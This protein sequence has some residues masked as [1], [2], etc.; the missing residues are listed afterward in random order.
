[1]AT[2]LHQ[3]RRAEQGTPLSGRHTA[4]QRTPQSALTPNDDAAEKAS[5]RRKKRSEALRKSLSDAFAGSSGEQQGKGPTL[6]QEAL[7]T[8]F[9]Q[10]IKLAAENKITDKN[11]WQLDL[12]Q[13]LPSIVQAGQAASLRGGGFNFQKMSGGLDAGVTIYSKRVDTTWKDVFQQLQGISSGSRGEDDGEDDAAGGDG[14]DDDD[15]EDAAAAAAKQAKSA[16]AAGKRGKA[17]AAREEATL[18]SADALRQKKVD[19]T[20]A[21]DPLFH[22]MSAL[23][24]EGGAKGLLLLNRSVYRGAAIMTDPHEVPE[25]QFPLAAAAEP[26]TLINMQPM[27]RQLAA[28]TATSSS[29]SNGGVLQLTPGLEQMYSLLEESLQRVQ[30][31]QQQQQQQGRSTVDV[32]AIMKQATRGLAPTPMPPRRRSSGQA[33]AGAGQADE[34]A[35]AADGSWGEEG[36]AGDEDY[37]GEDGHAGFEDDGEGEGEPWQQQQQQQQ[38][39]QSSGGHSMLGLGRSGAAE[40]DEVLDAEA[41]QQLL[42][43]SGFNAKAAPTTGGGWAGSSF[44]KYKSAAA[45][46]A[47]LGGSAAAAA[48]K[49]PAAGSKA[50]PGQQRIDF[51]SLPELPEGALERGS[52]KQTCL[53]GAAATAPTLLPQDL[54]YQASNL[55]QLFLKPAPVSC[56]SHLIRNAAAGGGADG[57]AA[58]GDWGGSDNDGEG[59]WGG[60]VYGDDDGEFGSGGDGYNAGDLSVG[61]PGFS[62]SGLGASEE[63][64]G[65]EWWGAEHTLLSA[66][67]RN[68]GLAVN[69]NRAAKQVD[70]RALKDLLWDSLV[71][72]NTRKTSA[73]H[74]EDSSSSSMDTDAAAAAAPSSQQPTIPFQEVIVS[75]P[76]RSA[77]GSLED[78]SVH[79]CFIC[80]L[81]L[82]NE[83]GL[84]IKAQEDLATLNISNVA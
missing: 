60:D 51:E 5:V 25:Q 23:F 71:T 14:E 64:G 46:I 63:P 54:H 20:F 56:I 34:D 65:S 29:S 82:A 73:A 83:K 67:K 26:D 53:V 79:M 1:M 28:C 27:R 11:V 66:P 74:N 59:G 78:V 62:S 39:R 2:P 18:A 38:R 40:A 52:R 81:H 50:R 75:V 24:D 61:D 57:G 31:Q 17:G 35:A 6:S 55:G 22:K 80:L 37:E 8:M 21:V 15:V 70:V 12:I 69:F 4:V 48:K 3:G 30:G 16:A 72:A 43:G 47:R 10:C 42:G 36:L 9:E 49:A 77:A 41:L 19:N 44:W 32:A 7:S 13:H 76:Q 68:A 33:A 45:A 58:G 84:V